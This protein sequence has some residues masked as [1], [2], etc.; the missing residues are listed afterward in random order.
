MRFLILRILTSS[1]LGMFHAYRRLG[2]ERSKQRAIN[3]DG[4]VVD[5]VFPACKDHELINMSLRFETDDGIG[6]AEQWL[7]R[8]EKNWRLEG[9]CPKDQRYSYV[10]AGCLFAMQV[11]ARTRP[12][13]GAWAVFAEDDRVTKAILADGESSRLAS[14]AMIALHDEEGL[15]A[16]QILAEARPG[17]FMTPNNGRAAPM[18]PKVG[19]NGIELPPDPSRLVSILASVGHTMPSAVADLV[20]NCISANATKIAINFGRPDDGHGRWMSI[21]DNGDGMDG[22]RL[23]E[24]MRIGSATD[25]ETNAL[26]KYGYGLKGASWSQ[27]KIFTVVTKQEGETAHHLTWD[28]DDMVGWLAKAEPLALWKQEATKLG[29]HGTVVLWEGMRPPQSM[30]ALRGLD[31]YST[32]VMLLERH[33]ALV[34]HRFL[35]GRARGRKAVTITINGNPVEPNNPFGHPLAS[36]YHPKI[37]RIPTEVG[38]GFVQV[39]AFL[40]PTE[41]EIAEHHKAEGADA[42]RRALDT[43]GLHGKRNDTQGLFIYRHD[44]LIRWGGWHQMWATNDEKTKLARVAVD[45]DSVLDDAFKINI[46]KQIVQLPQQLQV[47]IKQLA[48]AAR[49]ESQKKFGKEAKQTPTRPSAGQSLPQPGRMSRGAPAGGASDALPAPTGGPDTPSFPSPT[50]SVS[51]PQRVNVRA[52]RTSKFVWKVTKG[53]TGAVDLQVSDIDAAL[54]DLA[55]KIGEDH[56]AAACLVAFLGRLDEVGVQKALLAELAD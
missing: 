9:N 19:P 11:D 45:F 8:Q 42:V 52:V 20:D 13:N 39:E 6:Q 35:E 43:I 12:A 51:P 47:E 4:D 3:F 36:R 54:A 23:A 21:A 10:K 49:K 33:L 48:A 26:G 32:E 1:D 16:W 56:V 30:P 40:L 53:M 41:A 18:A 2:K 31:P 46:S 55:R 29:S 38:D 7:K 15:R 24:A 50:S 5:R 22:T 28:V 14:S 34:F 44:R 17:L 27:A 25:Y 37:I